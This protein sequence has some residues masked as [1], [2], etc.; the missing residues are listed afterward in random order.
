MAGMVPVI[1]VSTSESPPAA[2]ATLCRPAT[3]D[4][5]AEVSVPKPTLR[6]ESM[7]ILVPAAGRVRVPVDPPNSKAPP[8]KE[9]AVGVWVTVISVSSPYSEC[10]TLVWAFLTPAESAVTVMTRP[11]P[12]ARPSAMMLD[13]RARRRN[14][15]LR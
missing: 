7:S 8:P 13:C 10:S 14:S 11:M 1:L 5:L 9:P 15:R 12:S 4:R 6:S 3:E 2:A